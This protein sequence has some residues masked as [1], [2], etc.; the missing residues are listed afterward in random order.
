MKTHVLLAGAAVLAIAASDPSFAQGVGVRV[1]TG[2]RRD[3]FCARSTRRASKNMFCAPRRL[4]RTVVRGAGCQWAVSVPA[5]VELPA[6][7]SDWGPRHASRITA[8]VT[9]S[10]GV[11]FRGSSGPPRDLRSQLN[12][13]LLGAR[14]GSSSAPGLLMTGIGVA[15][16]T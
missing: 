15:R 13:K 5:D 6:V 12:C 16:R 11:Q 7:P 14:R 9:L 8:T 4:P 10:T 2:G 3:Y 1:A